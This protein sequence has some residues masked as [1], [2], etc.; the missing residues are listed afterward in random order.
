MSALRRR[1]CLL[2]LLLLLLLLGIVVTWIARLLGVTLDIVR[3]GE[4]RSIDAW[5]GGI[6]G[7]GVEIGC[8]GTAGIVVDGILGAGG[9]RRPGRTWRRGAR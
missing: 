4:G 8:I 3:C 7:R 9:P 1:V 2:L 5:T 6:R